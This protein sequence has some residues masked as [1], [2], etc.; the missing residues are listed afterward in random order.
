M[1]RVWNCISRSGRLQMLE[2]RVAT[3]K[4]FSFPIENNTSFISHL[5]VNWKRKQTRCRLFEAEIVWGEIFCTPGWNFSMSPCWFNLEPIFWK[6]WPGE[7]FLTAHNFA[8]GPHFFALTQ[9][10]ATK[11]GSKICCTHLSYTYSESWVRKD[12]VGTCPEKFSRPKFSGTERFTKKF[13]F[14]LISLAASKK[15]V[16]GSCTHNFDATDLPNS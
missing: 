15:K 1:D 8:N 16:S 6:L 10:R 14:S 11:T 2:L 5:L 12:S 13:H 7:F 9:L 3:R 4:A